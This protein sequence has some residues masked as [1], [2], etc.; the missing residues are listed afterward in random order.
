MDTRAWEDRLKNKEAELLME[1]NRLLWE[2]KVR[3]AEFENQNR[4]RESSGA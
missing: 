3:Q 1:K 4:A 2:D